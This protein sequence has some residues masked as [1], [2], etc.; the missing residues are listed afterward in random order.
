MANLP[1]LVVRLVPDAPIDGATFTTY[2]EN[3]QLQVLD[4]YTKAPVSDLVYS[5][6]LSLFSPLT[7]SLSPLGTAN[8]YQTAVS[9]P[10]TSP[11]NYQS[12]NDYGNQLTF[13]STDGISAG[14]FVF[15][16]DQKTIPPSGIYVTEVNQTTVTLNQNLP[17]YVPTGTV[18]SFVALWPNATPFGSGTAPNFALTTSGPAQTI[19][20]NPPSTTDLPAILAFDNPAGTAGVTVG[21]T[22]NPQ[23]GVI[24]DGTTVTEVTPTTVTIAPPLLV[25]ASPATVTFSLSEPYASLSLTVKTSTTTKL[26]FNTSTAG[27]A[28]GMTLSPQSGIPPGTV[29]TDVTSTTV[30]VAPALPAA[31]ALN[32]VVT[33]TFPLSSG[34]VQHVAEA[35]NVSFSGISVVATPMAVATAIIPLNYSTPESPGLLPL[36]PD[37]LNVNITA[38]RATSTGTP[39]IIPI[40]ETFYN[41]Q[42]QGDAPPDPSTYQLIPPSETSFYLTLPPQPGTTPVALTIPSDGSPPPFD[43]LYDAITSA[44]SFDWIKKLKPTD[45]VAPVTQP[46]AAPPYSSGTT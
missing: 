43:Q 33:F 18:V 17:N 8:F 29:V 16:T 28:V 9:S 14:A 36:I 25:V 40:N 34:I 12:S 6:P 44:L 5:S 19:D 35:L 42:W 22:V 4:A 15:S 23:A 2:L 7:Y 46:T 38:S 27:V 1:Y 10:V 39:Q 11:A 3:L 37:Y 41:V 45:Q 26:T 31:L 20:G 30:I 32:T 13:N 21:M 24:A